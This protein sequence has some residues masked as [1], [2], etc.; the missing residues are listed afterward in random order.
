MLGNSLASALAFGATVVVLPAQGDAT[1]VALEVGA[2]ATLSAAANWSWQ[3]DPIRCALRVTGSKGDVFVR[4]KYV[5]GDHVLFP[6]EVERAQGDGWE[7]VEPT[8]RR[9]AW[10]PASYITSPAGRRIDGKEGFT[11]EVDLWDL[12]AVSQPG[13]IRARFVLEA[14]AAAK[15]DA[16]K[17]DT[18][19]KTKAKKDFVWSDLKTPWLEVAIRPHAANAARL[20]ADDAAELRLRYDLMSFALNSTE[21]AARNRG[22]FNPGPGG[23]RSRR[24]QAIVPVAEQLVADADLSWR[25]RSRARLVLAND[26]V[27]MA[28]GAAGP[29]VEEHLRAAS[30]HLEAP[31]FEASP[32]SGGLASLPSGGL[33]PFRQMLLAFIAGCRGSGDP[34]QAHAELC[35][36]FPFFAMWWRAESARLL[37]R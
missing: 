6:F 37:R 29:E 34:Q 4:P 12:D 21:T 23:T 8:P 14:R 13:R 20:L 9:R 36:R 31:E 33:E 22:P 19:G 18:A 26:E 2:Q 25:L 7:P 3:C 30:A 1:A 24:W 10:H 28:L 15:E 16:A 11:F 17:K 5:R 32:P 27:E 35:R